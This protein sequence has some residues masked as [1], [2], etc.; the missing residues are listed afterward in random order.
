MTVAEQLETAV[1]E[2]GHGA[3]ILEYIE[4]DC[5]TLAP[6]QLLLAVR[7]AD[8]A[9]LHFNSG[10]REWVVT[11]NIEDDGTAK[12][13]YWGPVTLANGDP[14]TGESKR[15]AELEDLLHQELPEIV[16][17]EETPL[18]DSSAGR[19]YTGP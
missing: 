10:S 1:D 15:A 19:C 17:I 13:R 8:G 5:E 12:Y 4:D 16:P 2:R 11:A 9:A 14:G 18:G 7:W 6:F 3:Q